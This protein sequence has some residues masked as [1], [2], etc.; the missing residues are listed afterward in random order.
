MRIR[1]LLT[2][3][4]ATALLAC[5][6][7][8]TGPLAGSHLQFVHG[9]DREGSFSTLG[10]LEAGEGGAL[11]GTGVAAIRLEGEAGGWTVHAQRVP[12]PNRTDRVRLEL[13]GVTGAGTFELGIAGCL[14]GDA[15]PCRA[16]T[17]TLE[18]S[19]G[20]AGTVTRTYVAL[21]G[22]VTVDAVTTAAVSG[23]FEGEAVLST[24]DRRRLTVR[25][26]TFEAP[27]APVH[28]PEEA[29]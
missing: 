6:G 28:G 11:T 7:D 16:L 13:E 20:A 10:D 8:A 3:V 23:R 22:S 19:D 15:E 2:A 27:I 1:T 18:E 14:P 25:S 26:G 17:V 12:A 9:G 29:S 5:D 4:L 24:D 21:S